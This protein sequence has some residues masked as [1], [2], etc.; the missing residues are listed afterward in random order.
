MYCGIGRGQDTNDCR[1]SNKN[2]FVSLGSSHQPECAFFLNA[3]LCV[4]VF[5][6]VFLFTFCLK[7]M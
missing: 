5:V 2:R 3:I 7:L 1:K 6:V 4:A